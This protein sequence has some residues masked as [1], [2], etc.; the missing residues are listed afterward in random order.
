MSQ[1]KVQISS[2]LKPELSIRKNFVGFSKLHNLSFEQ[3]RCIYF[4]KTTYMC[5]TFL[6]NSRSM[7][8]P[9]LYIR[10]PAGIVTN[11][12]YISYMDTY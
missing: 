9:K 7:E 11:V 5:G 8:K 10:V 4:R 12:L 3:K 1:C 6:F 2:V